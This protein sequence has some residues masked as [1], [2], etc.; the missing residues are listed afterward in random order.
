M[1]ALTFHQVDTLRA[2]RGR[3]CNRLLNKASSTRNLI[4]VLHTMAK[5]GFSRNLWTNI[6][7]NLDKYILPFGQI[8][9][10]EAHPS[11]AHNGR[12]EG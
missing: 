1:V 11:P 3:P 10:S 5:E 12:A 8:P 9:H 4:Q 2:G 6:F 7:C